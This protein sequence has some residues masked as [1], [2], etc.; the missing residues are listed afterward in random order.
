MIAHDLYAT[1]I[2]LWVGFLNEYFVNYIFL[3]KVYQS[4]R[5]RTHN[6]FEY[7]IP[8]VFFIS[9]FKYRSH[10]ANNPCSLFF[11][12]RRYVFRTVFIVVLKLWTTDTFIWMQWKSPYDATKIKKLLNSALT[13]EINEREIFM[14]WVRS[15]SVE[16]GPGIQDKIIS[17]PRKWKI[18]I[19]WEYMIK[20]SWRWQSIWIIFYEKNTFHNW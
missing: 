15:G 5:H 20:Y 1:I 2:A 17:I 10:F 6:L 12:K 19:F 11:V 9:I 18:F 14:K 16:V 3:L 4:F 8:Y 13:E 7:H